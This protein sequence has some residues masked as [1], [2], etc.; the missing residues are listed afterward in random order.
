MF[1]SFCFTIATS[2]KFTLDMFVTY[3]KLISS[4]RQTR[5]NTSE[6]NNRK[7]SQYG[8][9]S[10][11]LPLHHRTTTECYKVV[12]SQPSYTSLGPKHKITNQLIAR[13]KSMYRVLF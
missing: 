7:D 12:I 5:C 6:Y 8:T 1:C 2:T 11:K 13:V 3:R 9:L 4:K 10:K